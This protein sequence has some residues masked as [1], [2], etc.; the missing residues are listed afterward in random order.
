[1][2]RRPGRPIRR[3]GALTALEWTY[4]SMRI[5]KMDIEDVGQTRRFATGLF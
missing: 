5:I 1:M 4:P 3:S 2:A